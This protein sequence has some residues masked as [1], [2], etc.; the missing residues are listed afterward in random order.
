MISARFLPPLK[1]LMLIIGTNRIG[2]KKDTA[3]KRKNKK[4]AY[5]NG[6]RIIKE[7]CGQTSETN[8]KKQG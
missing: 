2:G 7:K 8:F 1:Q 6:Y 4:K 3:K 5:S